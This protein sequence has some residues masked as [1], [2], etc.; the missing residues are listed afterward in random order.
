MCL[1]SA[2]CSQH[3]SDTFDHDWFLMKYNKDDTFSL[4]T[5]E[6]LFLS[7][8]YDIYITFIVDKSITNV[9]GNSISP[10]VLVAENL[11]QP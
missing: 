11:N 7:T 3:R 9:V 1:L 8:L 6:D 10:F 5:V 2:I 4:E